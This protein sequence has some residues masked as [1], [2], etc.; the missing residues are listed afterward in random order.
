M[1]FYLY[2]PNSF[3]SIHLQFHKRTIVFQLRQ[4]LQG[5][6]FSLPLLFA[7]CFQARITVLVPCISERCNLLEL[8]ISYVSSTLNIGIAVSSFAWNL[9]TPTITFSPVSIFVVF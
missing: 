4:L 5:M 6:M 8:L 3:S 7:D 9:F 1:L 2:S